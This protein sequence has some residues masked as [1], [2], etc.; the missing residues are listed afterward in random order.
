MIICIDYTT[1]DKTF[2]TITVINF[3][4]FL[5]SLQKDINPNDFVFLSKLYIKIVFGN[6]NNNNNNHDNNEIRNIPIPNHN[7]TT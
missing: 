5:G 4:S 6:N 3:L 1:K 7:I 2:Y